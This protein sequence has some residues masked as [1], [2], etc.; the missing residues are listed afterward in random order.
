MKMGIDLRI[1]F[2]GSNCS[3]PVEICNTRAHIGRTG[4]PLIIER[5]H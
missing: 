1:G 5:H 3:I 2:H 4:I